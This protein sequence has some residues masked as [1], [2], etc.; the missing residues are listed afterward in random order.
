MSGL[1]LGAC[2]PN[3][4]SVSLAILKLLAFNAEKVT[5]SHDPGHAPF[6]T[7]W[8][9]GVGGHKGTSYELGIAI[10]GPQTTS[11]Q[12]CNSAIENALWRSQFG[13]NGG[14]IGDTLVRFWL[15][16]KGFF[17]F[18]F[19][20]SVPNFA[21]SKFVKNCDRERADTHTRA[22]GRPWTHAAAVGRNSQV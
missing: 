8:H 17:F 3:L 14:K 11:E 21:N 22:R 10:I 20:T 5:G 6:Y 7:V 18:W 16:T 2:M 13:E 19:Q 1:S 9:S 12:F 15:P 4:K